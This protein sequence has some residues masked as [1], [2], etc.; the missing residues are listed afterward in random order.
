MLVVAPLSACSE[1]AP[2]VMPDVVGQPLDIGASEIEA[3]G[4]TD[5]VEVEGGGV[6]GVV[7]ESNW[8]ICEQTPSA[9]DPIAGTPV[10][11][12]D[13]ECTSTGSDT[14]DEA[15]DT[16]SPAATAEESETSEPLPEYAGPDYEIV[17]VDDNVGPA[18][19]SQFWI[20]VEGFDGTDSA[21]R[22]SI[23]QVISDVATS[24][25]TAE[26]LVEVV[27]DRQ[28]AEAE[29]IS[30]WEDFVAEHGE[31]YAIN[32][33]PQLEVEGW[34][35]SYSGGIDHDAGE[36]SD[37]PDAYQIAWWPAGQA[38]IETWR[39]DVPAGN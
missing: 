18:D 22:D 33:I 11:T 29:A 38:E 20:L 24:A 34:V 12:V 32:T 17:I 9:G 35:A 23:K 6:F 21:S 5:D 10:L 25:G 37:A 30:T 19:L 28:I 2:P 31:D 36:A 39:P 4:F 1:S 3:S 16:A 8:T 7:D 27:T 14:A 13:R 15:E 26:V